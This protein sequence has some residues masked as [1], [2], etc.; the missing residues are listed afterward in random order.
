MSIPALKREIQKRRSQ[1]RAA[2]KA[3]AQRIREEETRD[4]VDLF[5]GTPHAPRKAD[6][7]T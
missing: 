4:Q 1:V 6:D 5:S 3:L 7:A 2:E